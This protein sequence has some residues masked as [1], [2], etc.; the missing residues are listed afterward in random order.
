LT[1]PK[2]IA[3]VGPESTGKSE[4]TEALA[5]ELGCPFVKEIARSYLAE[6]GT[7]YSKADVE[8]IAKLQF[9]AEENAK[10]LN[11]E[12]I[13]CDTTL[14]VIKVWMDSAFGET[15]EWIIKSLYVPRYSHHLLTDIDIPWQPDPLR[16]HPMQRKYFLE[17]YKE[18]LNAFGLPF[19]LVSGLNSDR[20]NNAFNSLKAFG[21]LGKLNG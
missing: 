12:F 8:A 10:A 3:I 14:L 6:I 1:E 18:E 4:L 15:P 11:P 5:R 19:S 20:L 21:L 9:E 13:I 16:E 2:L 7:F 17:K